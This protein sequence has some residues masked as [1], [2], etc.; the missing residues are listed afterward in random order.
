MI[1]LDLDGVVVNPYD[2][3]NY[4]LHH[5]GY[6]TKEWNVWSDYALKQTYPN[7]PREV[8][9]SLFREPTTVLN[10]I[11]FE[12]AWYWINHHEKTD[13]VCYITA[14]DKKL[15]GETYRNLYDWGI[16][17]HRI[18]F[19]RYKTERL[20]MLE[21]E[22]IHIE[23]FVED[24]AATA[25]GAARAGFKTYLRNHSYNKYDDCGDAIRIDTLWEIEI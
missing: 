4:R 1:C 12:D 18:Y 17:L 2:E 22:G 7:I 8:I 21:R 5:M 25:K 9:S 13:N 15:E 14:R 6:E 19:D 3:I 10:A 11:P 16:P 23:C 24:N 20:R